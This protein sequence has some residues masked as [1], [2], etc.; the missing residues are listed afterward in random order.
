TQLHKFDISSNKFSGTL[1]ASLSNFT[2]L[3]QFDVSDNNLSGTLPPEFAQWTGL[4]ILNASY[5]NISGELSSDFAALTQLHKFDISSNKFS[6]TLPACFSNWTRLSL[7][8]VSFNRV[9]GTLPPEYGKMKAINYFFVSNNLLSGTLPSNYSLWSGL[10]RF[11]VGFNN[12]TGTLPEAYSSWSGAFEIVFENNSFA[13]TLPVSYS[14]WIKMDSFSAQYNSIGGGLPD[15]YGSWSAI[16]IFSME[17]NQLS[18]TLPSNYTHW[19]GMMRFRASWNNLSGTLPAWNMPNLTLFFV[20]GNS[21]S[22]NVG[23]YFISQMPALISFAISHNNFSGSLPPWPL[24]TAL[25][26]QNNTQLS[27][28]LEMPSLYIASTCAT[29][30]CSVKPF[31]AKCFPSGGMEEYAPELTNYTSLSTKYVTNVPSCAS[32]PPST[33]T[34][35]SP[36]SAGAANDSISTP[37]S[38][39]FS[40]KATASI[41]T[42]AAGA[43]AVSGADPT[44][45]QM[46][47]SIL[48]SPC[49]CTAATAPID[50]SSTW[51]LALSPF[52]FL[53]LSWVAIGNSLLCCVFLCA[54]SACVWFLVRA[55]R[56]R[57]RHQTATSAHTT[58][59]GSWLARNDPRRSVLAQ[60]RFPNLTVSLVLLLNPGIVR[61][62][63]SVIA[64][65]VSTSN[66]DGLVAVASIYGVTVVGCSLAA[67][68][69]VVYRHIRA[70]LSAHCEHRNERT[71]QCRDRIQFVK[72]HD[73]SSW[74]S[75]CR[76]FPLV[77]R[78]LLPA[79]MWSPDRARKSYGGIVSAFS[80]RKHRA[81][82]VLP[83]T[84]LVL[85]ILNGF[86]ESST[87][88]NA[89]QSLTMIVLACVATFFAVVKPHRA[90]LASYLTCAS[91]LL[92]CVVTLLAMLC[93]LG[94]I[95][96]SAV[97]G[98][99][100]FA[101]VAMM[102]MK[103]YHIALP[104]VEAWLMA[105]NEAGNAVDLSLPSHEDIPLRR[106]DQRQA[107]RDLIEL[108]TSQARRCV[109]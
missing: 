15:A 42:V 94:S 10:L 81:W 104:W 88:C 38:A 80:G 83:L 17:R 23:N 68:E 79:G 36:H 101:S 64:A 73:V 102:M 95:D 11:K 46:L 108:I 55:R 9:T 109:R 103:A 39:S 8:D 53:G 84:N 107:L 12:F 63:T 66:D 100:V 69:L 65:T 6:G 22:G 16:R 29:R 96:R 49:T 78:V 1:P 57:S 58:F 34:T 28:G 105:R 82:C 44:D 19:K 92:S 47:V 86:G 91:L 77:V 87:T 74:A 72:H 50:A 97:D 60:L 51:Q 98:F 56:G 33:V 25:D 93:R 35:A 90:L 75:S 13:G 2:H 31:F 106:K 71:Q 5:N 43:S 89:L 61:A 76:A 59:V 45:A 48:T 40:L 70:E 99:G 21:L 67:L 18:G 20:S 27:G 54:H 24:M 3:L 62:V 52:S 4:Q 37:L 30:L 7:F 14:S 32:T 85:Q 26:A 41:A